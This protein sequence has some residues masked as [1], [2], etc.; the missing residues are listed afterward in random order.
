MLLV[1]R[2]C[3]SKKSLLIFFVVIAACALGQAQANHSQTNDF[4]DPMGLA[5]FKNYTS[6]RT[7][8]GNRFVFSNDDSKR[9]MPGQ[10]MEVANIS[11]P[12]MV[13]H[14]WITVAQN[15]FAWPRLL[16]F[17]RRLCLLDWLGI[18]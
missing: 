7:A 10:T 9:I 16:R 12:G 4:L 15:E 6:E 11:G 8:T 3:M 5:R 18:V 14:I 13:T 1:Q 17:R 2:A